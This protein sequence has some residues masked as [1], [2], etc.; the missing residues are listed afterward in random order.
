MNWLDNGDVLSAIGDFLT[1]DIGR[2][3]ITTQATVA[4]D[5]RGMGRFLAKE[6]L[7]ICG[8]EVAEAVFLHLD[9]GVA[10]FDQNGVASD[11]RQLLTDIERIIFADFGLPRT[12]DFM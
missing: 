3:D 7:V 8:L 9:A 2:G 12:D 4:P 1:E 11:D 10:C 6:Y 5:V